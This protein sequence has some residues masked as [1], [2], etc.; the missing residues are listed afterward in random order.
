MA[1]ELL[2]PDKEF[3]HHILVN[4]EK[5]WIASIGGITRDG[6]RP[7]TVFPKEKVDQ[8]GLWYGSGK[9]LDRPPR[10]EIAICAAVL[11]FVARAPSTSEIAK[12]PTIREV[13]EYTVRPNP[14]Y[15]AETPLFPGTNWEGSRV[16]YEEIF[17]T[18]D[19]IR[20][21]K[22][23]FPESFIIKFV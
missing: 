7:L 19:R 3:T 10:P 4:H 5:G 1:F 9:L 2:H 13:T 12:H 11:T 6:Y 18:Y 17:S 14:Y 21:N 22:Q 23:K 16:I 20:R 15:L 8:I